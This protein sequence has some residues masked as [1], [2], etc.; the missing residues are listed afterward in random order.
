MAKLAEIVDL[1]NTE[2]QRT[3]FGAKRFQKGR[4]NGITELVTT[5]ENETVPCVVDNNGDTTKLGMDDTYSFEVYHRMLAANFEV[6]EDDFGASRNRR[7]ISDMVIVMMGDRDRL[8][9]TNEQIIS[10]LA[11]GFPVILPK[12]EVL[13]LSIQSAEFLF[14]GFDRDREAVWT[15]EFKTETRSLKPNTLLVSFRYQVIT[16]VYE[17][18]LSLCN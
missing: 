16:E 14:Q 6:G 1:V 11:L 15:R 18:C 9:L 8:E 12:D 13:A 7:E 10:G 2:L 3:Q 17:N 4:W 5:S